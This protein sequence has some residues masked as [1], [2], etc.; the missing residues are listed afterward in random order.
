VGLTPA[1]LAFGG[2]SEERKRACLNSESSHSVL[3]EGRSCPKTNKPDT[4]E[5]HFY[6]AVA[7][8]LE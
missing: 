3:S 5:Y 1:L 6:I 8:F 2:F 4:M 7:A